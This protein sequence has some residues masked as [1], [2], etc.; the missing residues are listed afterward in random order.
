MDSISQGII[1]TAAHCI[2]VPDAEASSF[3]IE[4]MVFYVHYRGGEFGQ[5]YAIKTIF[6]TVG[7]NSRAEAGF[8]FAFASTRP[9]MYGFAIGAQIELTPTLFVG[10]PVT[11]SFTAYGYPGWIAGGE[12]PYKCIMARA[13][14]NPR[15]ELGPTLRIGSGCLGFSQG[16][17]GGL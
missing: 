14:E 8:D 10:P 6:T 13:V 1:A 9:D 4:N 3:Q 2:L 7:W 16:S 12:Y 5:S 11:G 17:S 15:Y